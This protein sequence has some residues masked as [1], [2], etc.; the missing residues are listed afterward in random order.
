MLPDGR[1]AIRLGRSQPRDR[2]DARLGNQLIGYGMAG[3]TFGQNSPA[4]QVKVSVS[5][6][7]TALV[8]S[9]ATDMGTGTYTIATPAGGPGN[10]GLGLGQ[11]RVEI[12]DSD[13]PPAPASGGSQQATALAGAIHTVPAAWCR[14]SSTWPQ[15]TS[16]RR[17]GAGSVRTSP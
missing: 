3:V 6:D 16:S 11:V 4:C 1:A 5:R 15:A 9:A 10:L 13:L 7:G 12:G 14:P 8:R 17:C 2:L